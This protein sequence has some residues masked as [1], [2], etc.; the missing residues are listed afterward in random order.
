MLEEPLLMNRALIFLVTGLLMGGT[1]SSSADEP[2]FFILAPSRESQ[3]L[4][5]V[6]ATPRGDELELVEAAQFSLDFP[7]TTITAS[8]SAPVFYITSNQLIEGQPAAAFVDFRGSTSLQ[9][10]VEITN[11]QVAHGYAYL[12]LDRENRF[13]LGANYSEGFID[14]YELNESG[15]PTAMVST[16]NEGRKNAHCV[17]PSPNNRFVY[18]PYVKDTNAL[19]QYAFDGETGALTALDKLNAEPPANTGPRHLAYHPTLPLLY[20]SNEQGVG[21]SAYEM[22]DDGQLSLKQVC[23]ISDSTA[24][25][26]GVSASDI[27]IHP[28]GQFL[29]TGVRGPKH[30]YNWIS[31]Y[32]ILRDGSVKHLGLT[33][34][35][36]IPWGLA[37]SP[38]GDYLLA[39]GFGSGTLMAYRVGPDG[40]L[41]RAGTLNWD[42]KISDL[43]TW[44]GFA[45][46]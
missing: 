29:F 15:Y 32:E 1:C 11:F 4:I 40:A 22:A 18:V 45:A 7:A 13:L 44:P 46:E 34:A 12:S 35:D 8:G 39:S 30:D 14:V 9:T 43:V 16:L 19:Y 6:K 41:T 25:S 31:S 33:P 38:Q 21:V 27:A 28:N 24:P 42:E 3:S 23:E 20:F 36:K 2:E 26:E 37:L 10:K 5:S 17:I